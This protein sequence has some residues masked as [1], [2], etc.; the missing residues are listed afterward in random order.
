MLSHDSDTLRVQPHDLVDAQLY[1]N[2]QDVVKA[3]L[4]YFLQH[5]PNLRLALAI[6]LYDRDDD[7]VVSLGRA[8]EIAGMTFWEM[9]DLLYDKGVRLRLGPETLEEALEEVETA[10]RWANERIE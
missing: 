7:K 9:R 8:A 2:E 6:H 5:Q 1:A 4:D 10:R 3:A